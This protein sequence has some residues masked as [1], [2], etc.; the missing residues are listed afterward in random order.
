MVVAVAVA[1]GV[2]A[3]VVLVVLL[4][5]FVRHA[6]RLSRAASDL[7]RAM[8][9]ALEEMRRDAESAR[10][11]VERIRKQKDEIAARRRR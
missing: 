10:P 6:A 9:P 11:A 4:I 3:L 7:Q 1:V 8:R 2:A 5:S